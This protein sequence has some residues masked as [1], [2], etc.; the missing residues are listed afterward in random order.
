MEEEE[1]L[2]KIAPTEESSTE[3]SNNNEDK[4]IKISPLVERYDVSKI[5]K[6]I[7][8]GDTGLGESIYDD[9]IPLALVDNLQQIRAERQPWVHQA[10][11]AIGGGI[12]GGLMTAGETISYILDIPDHI[13]S[14]GRMLGLSDDVETVE[15]N[16]MA[17]G[18]KDAKEHALEEWFPIYRK[19]PSKIIDFND[20]GFYYE[21]FRGILD[22]AVGFG[23]TGMGAGAAVKLTGKAL[24][25][26][27]LNTYNSMMGRALGAVGEGLQTGV[28]G[29]VTAAYLTNYGESKMMALE[30]YEKAQSEALEGYLKQYQ[31][32]TGGEM[33]SEKELQEFKLDSKIEA[34][35]KANHFMLVNKVFMLTDYFQLNKMFKATGLTKSRNLAD[36]PGVINFMKSQLSAGPKE[37]FEEIGQNVAQMEGIYQ[38]RESLKAR[39]YKFPEG[40]LDNMSLSERIVDF[41][42]SE[43]ALLEGAMGF[44]GGPIQYAITQAPFEKGASKQNFIDQNTQFKK[45]KQYAEDNFY[46][47]F[48]GKALAE[49]SVELLEDAPIEFQNDLSFKRMALVNFKKGTTAQFEQMLVEASENTEYSEDERN[50]AKEK[51]K[52]LQEFETEYNNN[53][54]KYAEIS[55]IV[56]EEGIKTYY[57]G[58]INTINEN[59]STQEGVL[60]GAVSNYNDSNKTEHT[61]QELIDNKGKSKFLKELAPFQQIVSKNT[62]KQQN[63]ANVK[64]KLN[65]TIGNIESL[66]N[67]VNNTILADFQEYF[68]NI[69]NPTDETVKLGK[70]LIK[71][72]DTKHSKYVKDLLINKVN[73]LEKFLKESKA[74]KKVEEKGGIDA[75]QDAKDKD[76][77]KEATKE[78]TEQTT[79][80]ATKTNPLDKYITEGNKDGVPQETAEDANTINGIT[81]HDAP[82]ER[83]YE[84]LD[85]ESMMQ[86]A[87]ADPTINIDEAALDKIEQSI[88]DGTITEEKGNVLRQALTVDES[89]VPNNDVSNKTNKR[90]PQAAANS[91]HVLGTTDVVQDQAIR[92]GNKPAENL[93]IKTLNKITKAFT[94][95]LNRNDN[96]AGKPVTFRLSTATKMSDAKRKILDKFKAGKQLNK[97]EIGQ[98]P[99]QVVIDEEPGNVFTA[100]YDVT[101]DGTASVAETTFRTNILESIK[102]G[103]NPKGEIEYQYSGAILNDTTLKSVK[104]INELKEEVPL[105]FTNRDGK[106]INVNKDKSINRDHSKTILTG[107]NIWAGIFFTEVTDSNGKKIPLKLN[108]RKLNENER[109]LILGIFRY[110]LENRGINHTM[111]PISKYPKLLELLSKEDLN[112]LGQNANLNKVLSHLIFENK[113]SAITKVDINLKEGTLSLGG[114]KYT[115]KDLHDPFKVAAAKKFLLANKPRNISVNKIIS[116]KGYKDFILDNAILGTDAVVTEAGEVF[117]V[118]E[119]ANSTDPVNR[120]KT[121]AIY[122][123]NKLTQGQNNAVPNNVTGTVQPES[124]T[125]T[126]TPKGKKEQ[127]YTIQGNKIINSENKE[128]FKEDTVDRRKI[129]ANYAIAT[130][131]AEIIEY[132]NGKYIVNNKQVIMSVAS[133]NIM[134]WKDNSPI[135]KAIL[136]KSKF[137]NVNQTQ[138]DSI[139]ETTKPLDANQTFTNITEKTIKQVKETSGKKEVE[140]KSQDIDLFKNAI[141]SM[142][143]SVDKITK[144][145]NPEEGCK[146]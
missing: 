127:V 54:S 40:D 84:E 52:E 20:S 76:N 103:I 71:Q 108:A 109:E 21:A 107:D 134:Q 16:L 13:Q 3:S 15:S 89:A 65:E 95:F 78:T 50:Q 119:N 110:V 64:T 141:T 10:G 120:Y 2:I 131:R 114:T 137:K 129:F 1:E 69:N 135:R 44:F 113:T 25:L 100:L 35:K 117:Q 6:R 43:Q 17:E 130:G 68:T 22:S 118:D 38:A 125:I 41:A 87:L 74:N 80:E 133:G 94:E 36:K 86:I 91:N 142:Q 60:Q 105:M 58:Y 81:Y 90:S 19:D 9:D 79:T 32:D 56:L 96:K 59:I 23:L 75:I 98:I 112:Y 88:E 132:K 82:P 33:P 126:Y 29:R 121:K 7:N 39:N 70:Q 31:I 30:L 62:A 83:E 124:N 8:V 27:R 116:E 123:K 4:L 61:V 93:G 66:K 24:R 57:E 67:K 128:V 49:E 139:K 14:T 5:N 73:Q 122:I 140:V 104:L 92:K 51:I 85:I 143:S 106:L 55:N 48:S 72:V 34:G 11:S 136:D 138:Q 46:N 37:A 26:A 111:E 53:L 45:N 99:I 97:W 145:K 63:L 77:I 47:V 12:I 146:N 42:T 102:N 28:T 144:D 18:F 115:Y 101:N